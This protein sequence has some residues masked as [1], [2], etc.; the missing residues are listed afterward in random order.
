MIVSPGMTRSV[1]FLKNT[2]ERKFMFVGKS[3][4]VDYL[5]WASSREKVRQIA[6]PPRG[7][8]T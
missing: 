1:R 3:Q 2:R 8:G 7:R 5:F 4:N 6:F